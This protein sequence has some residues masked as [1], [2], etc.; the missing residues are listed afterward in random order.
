LKS[1]AAV[2]PKLLTSVESNHIMNEKEYSKSNTLSYF[3]FHG[4]E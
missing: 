1:P 3:I 2:S 4:G